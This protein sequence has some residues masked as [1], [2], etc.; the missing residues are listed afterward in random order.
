M[1]AETQHHIRHEDG[2]LAYADAC[3]IAR[4]IVA[5]RP[6]QVVFLDLEATTHT[7]TAAL[8]RLILL[9]RDL[10]RSGRDLRIVGLHG[11][12]AGLYEINRLGNL[13]PRVRPGQA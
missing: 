9:R 4:R 5:D 2:L 8:A 6:E 3:E 13:L 10:L 7:T 1:V 11:T 12:A